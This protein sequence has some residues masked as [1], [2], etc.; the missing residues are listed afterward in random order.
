MG[1][2]VVRKGPI[3]PDYKEHGLDTLSIGEAR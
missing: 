1:S 3:S 2:G